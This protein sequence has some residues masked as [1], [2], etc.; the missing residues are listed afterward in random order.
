MGFDG[1]ITLPSYSTFPHARSGVLVLGFDNATEGKPE[2]PGGGGIKYGGDGVT[3]AYGSSSYADDSFAN[4]LELGCVLVPLPDPASVRSV[5][6]AGV[7]TGSFEGD[8]RGHHRRI[9]YLNRDGGWADAG[10]GVKILLS[11]VKRFGAKVHTGKS[12]SKIRQENGRV[13]GVSCVDGTAY[14]ADL[15]IVATGSW[16]PSTFPDLSLEGRC[17]STGYATRKVH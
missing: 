11:K 4:D 14:D 7:H 3:T 1:L 8:D 2:P 12:V 5:F 6:P 13:A 9:G 16:T 10:Q 17:L 15:V